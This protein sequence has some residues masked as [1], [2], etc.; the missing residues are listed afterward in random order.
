[1]NPTHRLLE[2]LDALRSGAMKTWSA[3]PW[4]DIWNRLRQPKSVAF[5]LLA[6]AASLVIPAMALSG[7]ALV[8]HVRTEAT[9]ARQSLVRATWDISADVDREISGLI[10]VLETLSTSSSLQRGDFAQFHERAATALGP[11][12]A[13]VLLIDTSQ[14]QLL[15]TRVPYGTPLPQ[16]SDPE[17]VRAVLAT[18]AVY[19]SDSFMGAVAGQHVINIALP[20]MRKSAVAYVL[21]LTVNV[22]RFHNMIAAFDAPQG[23]TVRLV[24]RKGQQLASTS[25]DSIALI[26]EPGGQRLSEHIGRDGASWIEASTVSGLTGWRTIVS[27]PR[28][29]IDAPLWRS[30]T[31]LG[32]TG[33]LVS[34]LAV[35]CCLY[36][37]RRMVRAMATI[38]SATY[39]LAIGRQVRPEPLP[40]IEATNVMNALAQA[41][42]LIDAR[43][44]QVLDSEARYQAALRVGRMGSWETDFIAGTRT[45]SQE[46][47]ELFQITLP[48]NKGTVG[49]PTDELFA[50]MHPD[51]RHL[52]E[53]YHCVLQTQDEI[54]AAYRIVL[55]DG[56]VRHVTGRG[57]VSARCV[58]GRPHI[59]VSVVADTT[60]RA[61][62]EQRAAERSRELEAAKGRFEALV[63]ATAQIVWSTTAAG[64]VVEDS[65]TWRAYTGQT[66]EQWKG[67][68]WLQAVHPDD[69]ERTLAAWRAAV[70]SAAPYEVEYRLQH[71][72]GAYR[73]TVARGVPLKNSEGEVTAWVGMNED[74]A[75]RKRRDEQLQLV[76]RELSHRTK[77][78]LAV[79]QSI[80]SRTFRDDDTG[81]TSVQTFVDRL[82]GIAVSHDLLVLGQWSGASLEDLVIAHL[83]PFG[84]IPSSSVS[85]AGPPV[86]LKPAVAQTIGLGLHELA[87]N[88]AKYGAL[89]EGGGRLQITWEIGGN[90]TGSVLALEW[91]EVPSGGTQPSQRAG[92]GRLLLERIVA[93]SMN[94]S[95]VYRIDEQGVFWRLTAPIEEVRTGE[96]GETVAPLA[97]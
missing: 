72:S 75:D 52:L 17:S 92:F 20:I 41:S 5:Y 71:V 46:A 45:W 10:T 70:A 74:I 97:P 16:T 84:A 21:V 63:Q 11:R 73:W 80:A 60:D 89:A 57:K 18:R 29:L 15:N 23:W 44:R 49:G 79:I 58:D 30:L 39:R 59:L 4:Q 33:F 96:A 87:T 34:L 77:N 2:R 64:E 50:A 55:P 69:R 68:G 35:A 27:A 56:S 7:Y 67:T 51:D 43:T 9:A 37:S 95:S 91:R 36:L 53:H 94:G 90:G 40:L 83:R 47:L 3:L 38:Q 42:I 26:P 28:A 85:I 88:A 48:S 1:M 62:A 25:S 93:S 24:D 66:F 8:S 86:L 32:T 78:L 22:S 31:W 19:I 12:Q 81:T 65:P 13:Y 6:M 61:L 14:Q 82:H 76:M 54:D